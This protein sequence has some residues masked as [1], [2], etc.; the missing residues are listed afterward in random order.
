M[1]DTKDPLRGTGRT[2]RLILEYV[3]T[4]L[5]FPG[6]TVIPED[7]DPSPTA[8]ANVLNGIATILSILK[9]DNVR[10]HKSIMVFPRQDVE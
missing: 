6:T 8:N 1:T 2:T 4:L 9:I 10:D 7:H 5:E 3:N